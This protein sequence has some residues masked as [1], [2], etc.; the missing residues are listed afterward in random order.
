MTVGL[1]QPYSSTLNCRRGVLVLQRTV[2]SVSDRS[3]AGDDCTHRTLIPVVD[4]FALLSSNHGRPSDDGD[5]QQPGRA[6]QRRGVIPAWLG[7]ARRSHRAPWM[8]DRG[9]LRRVRQCGTPG[10]KNGSRARRPSFH[11]D[12]AVYGDVE[13]TDAG[14]VSKG[15]LENENISNGQSE[16]GRHTYEL[17]RRASESGR[18]SLDSAPAGN[19]S[20][21]DGGRGPRQMCCE[22]SG[23]A[24][25]HRQ[26]VGRPRGYGKLRAKGAAAGLERAP[27]WR[28]A[29][30][31]PSG[32][33]STLCVARRRQV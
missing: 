5:D 1:R 3:L 29:S 18:R 4:P 12:G 20:G 33:E 9:E 25:K 17:R 27:P 10:V 26:G 23:G 2:V 16:D 11:G 13:D 30:Y 6:H 7:S 8:A 15:D 24:S 32:T 19:A 21:S 28:P 22:S 31:G 14:A